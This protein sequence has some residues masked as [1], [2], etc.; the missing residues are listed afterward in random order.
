LIGYSSAADFH[1]LSGLPYQTVVLFKIKGDTIR[2]STCPFGLTQYVPTDPVST[3]AVL[4]AHCLL[5]LV[6]SGR[7]LPPPIDINIALYLHNSTSHHEHPYS[8]YALESCSLIFSVLS[9]YDWPCV[10]SSS[11]VGAAA[12]CFNDVILQYKYLSILLVPLY[13]TNSLTS[14]LTHQFNV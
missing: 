7:L 9:N 14:F 4:S 8:K 11:T 6:L 12:H 5:P 13:S 1:K 2:T 10:C 3:I